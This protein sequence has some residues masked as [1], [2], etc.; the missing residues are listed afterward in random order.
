MI[1]QQEPTKDVL[2]GIQ[3]ADRFAFISCD[4]VVFIF[5]FFYFR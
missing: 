3:W 5:A 4:L 2:Q 1:L